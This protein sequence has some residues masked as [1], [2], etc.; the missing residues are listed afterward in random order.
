MNGLPGYVPSCGPSPETASVLILQEFSHERAMLLF[1]IWVI[2]EG[3]AELYLIVIRIGAYF[4]ER[5]A[6]AAI[7]VNKAFREST[8]R[9]AGLCP[10][11]DRACHP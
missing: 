5:S 6:H 9:T 10:M 3:R 7:R 1:P 11:P 2:R 8:E 4:L